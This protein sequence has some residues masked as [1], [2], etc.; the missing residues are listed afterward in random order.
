[1]L[2]SSTVKHPE[3]ETGPLAWVAPSDRGGG[4]IWVA[5]SCCRQAKEAGRDVT[6]V[7]LEPL[8]RETAA[9]TDYPSHSLDVAPPYADTPARFLKWVHANRPEFVFLNNVDPL[10]HCLDYLPTNTRCVYVVHDTMSFYYRAVLRHE[11]ALDGVVAVSEETAR[12]FRSR[13][14][15]PSKLRVIHNGALYPEVPKEG[16]ARTDLVFLGGDDPR[17]GAY[18]LLQVWPRLAALAPEARLFWLGRVDAAFRTRIDALPERGRIELL[19]H[20]PRTEVFARLAAARVLLMLSRA[21]AC[22]IAVLEAMAMGCQPVAWDI[23]ATGTKEI[24]PAAAQILAPLGDNKALARR[25]V[26]A[27]RS[28]RS[29]SAILMRHARTYLTEGR[30]WSDYERFIEDIRQRP[31]A[32]RRSVHAPAPIYK[33]PKRASYY[34]PP[35]IWS[36]LRPRLAQSA[37]LYYFV[38]NLF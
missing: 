28:D 1:M 11:E 31:H 17:K 23:E 16:S 4:A 33:W 8:S 27:L 7:T 14:R 2:E 22:S 24:V 9:R 37:W 21:E 36:W 6:L 26:E 38:R 18:D 34:V 29:N 25:I 13:M 30:M 20:V 5:D 15:D 12:R 32:R 19:G 35:A 10:D 3:P